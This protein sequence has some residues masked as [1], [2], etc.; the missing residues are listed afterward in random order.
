MLARKV[1]AEIMGEVNRGLYTGIVDSPALSIKNAYIISQKDEKEILYG[2][3][4]A[5]VTLKGGEERAVIAP[6][7]EIYYE[8]EIREKLKGFKN[9]EIESIS[10]LYEKSCGGLVFYRNKQGVR[11]LLVKNHNGRYWSFP[12]GHMEFGETEEET[13]IRE[14]KEETGLDVKL[15]KGFREVSDYCPFGKIRKRVVFFLAQA[16]TDNVTDQESEIDS[17]IW[18]DLQQA[19]KNC[20]YENDLKIID[21]AEILINKTK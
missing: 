14:I 1:K 18:V 11:V 12:K 5:V 19:R 8:P 16:F 20:T 7:K 4:I 9:A 3:V 21:K 15:L 6:E 17:H 2:T 13:A 10:C